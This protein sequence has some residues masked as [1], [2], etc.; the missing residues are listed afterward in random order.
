M[1]P[2]DDRKPWDGMPETYWDN[3]PAF[4]DISDETRGFLEAACNIRYFDQTQKLYDGKGKVVDSWTSTHFVRSSR[5]QD[6]HC[7]ESCRGYGAG[8]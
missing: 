6:L 8:R 5:R 7:V 4:A 3:V 2:A 1:T